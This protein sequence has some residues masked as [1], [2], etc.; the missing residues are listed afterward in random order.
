MRTNMWTTLRMRWVVWVLVGGAALPLGC[1]TTAQVKQSDQGGVIALRD[2]L[3]NPVDSSG[4]DEARK[5]AKEKMAEHCGGPK[6][7]RIVGEEEV[8]VGSEEETQTGSTQDGRFRSGRAD[9]TDKREWRITYRCKRP[10][11]D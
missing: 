11:R 2:Y 3:G 5:E 10:R 6:S 7:F 4:R 9:R 1:A 8:V